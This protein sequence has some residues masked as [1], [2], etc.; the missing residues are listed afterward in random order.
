LR[1]GVVFSSLID[2]LL[3]KE[4]IMEYE[5]EIPEA[6][7]FV[8]EDSN[9]E[10]AKYKMSILAD[11]KFPIW[12]YNEF[13]EQYMSVGEQSYEDAL[14]DAYEELEHALDYTISR[15][16]DNRE[17]SAERMKDLQSKIED[18]KELLPF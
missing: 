6:V 11:H 14:R 8:A 12:K 10:V 18:F 9:L 17:V 5:L 16:R 13:S 3:T 7:N 15:V 2:I 4:T 1:F